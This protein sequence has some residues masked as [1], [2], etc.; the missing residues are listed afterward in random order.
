MLLYG[1]APGERSSGGIWKFR[2][3]SFKCYVAHWH[4]AYSSA[5]VYVPIW[6]HFMNHAVSWN[7]IKCE[8]AD[9][10]PAV[11]KCAEHTACLSVCLQF[12]VHIFSS[13]VSCVMWVANCVGWDR[14]GGRCNV[15]V[16]FTG[17]TNVCQPFG[18]EWP[19][20]GSTAQL[21]SRRCI[22]NTYSTNICTE[23][24]KRAA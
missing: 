9:V 10:N 1:S 23:Y 7:K 8:C 24:F 14:E 20:Y 16:V 12:T 22:L 3:S 13:T 4:T 5:N 19:I 17:N 6:V 21:T 2:T 15:M 18:A 11:V